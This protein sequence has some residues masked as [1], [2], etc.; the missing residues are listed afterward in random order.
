MKY[1]IIGYLIGEGFRNVF[2]NKKSTFACL[3]IM[4]ATML[5]FGIFFI[6]GENIDHIIKDV[7]AS[8]GMEV[9]IKDDATESDIEKLGDRISEITGVNGRPKYYSKEAALQRMK[10]RWKDNQD[11]IKDQIYS[12]SYMVTLTD[13][14]LSESVREEISKLENVKKIT[15]GSETI[16]TLLVVSKW[17]RITTIVILALLVLISVFIITNTIKLTVHARRKEISIMKYVG[18]TNGFIRWPFIVEGIII[19]VVAGLIS[20]LLVGIAYNYI[21]GKILDSNVVKNVLQMTL[22]GFD[23]MFNLIL[24]VYMV[25]G[26]GI[27]IVGSSIS[28]RKYL[29]V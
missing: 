20:L 6:I 9:F 17:I 2:K 11:L 24:V 4:C 28:M 5:I 10:E 27:G 8:Q 19:G 21:A 13:L 18:A 26:V 14:S 16:K 12:A 15:M 7:K 1:N 3:G 25:L 22:L 23:Q 29:N